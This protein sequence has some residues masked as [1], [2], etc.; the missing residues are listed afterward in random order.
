[1]SL[2]Q[3]RS[4]LLEAEEDRAVI[5]LLTL[6]SQKHLAFLASMMI[7]ADKDDSMPQ[8]QFKERVEEMQRLAA[9]LAELARERLKA[10]ETPIA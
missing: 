2:R 8:K 1:M 5:D 3:G 6:I 7:H 4:L 9:E 10:L